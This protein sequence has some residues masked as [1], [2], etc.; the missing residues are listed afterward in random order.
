MENLT[1]IAVFVR[2]VDNGS[3]TKTAEQLGFSRAVISKYVKR[4]EERLGARLLNRTT[5]RLSLTEAGATL[6]EG[7]YRALSQID[8]AEQEIGQLQTKPRGVL[9]VSVPMSFGILHISPA[10]PDFLA[11][12]PDLTVDMKMDDRFVDVVEEGFDLAIRI[13]R[14]KDSTL[15]ARN[16]APSRFVLC[17]A[18]SYLKRHGIPQTPEELREHNCT[19]YTYSRSP[20]MW[21]FSAPDGRDIAVPV[22]G[23]LRHNSGL[24]ERE[25]VLNGLGIM[26][27]PTF[28]VGDLIREGRLQTV[29][30]DYHIAETSVYAVYPERRYLS[31]KVRA[32]IDFFLQ[33]FGPQ[34]YWDQF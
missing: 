2:V 25:A 26:L 18:E 8:E 19:I 31:P 22:R 4:L 28:Y 27:S 16:L 6:Y 9:K 32:F 20:H 3:F 15:V 21:R 17:A 13:T 12:H 11:R 34:P 23:N 1:D 10:L 24:A 30:T 7:S 33:R 5:R 14:L 29:L